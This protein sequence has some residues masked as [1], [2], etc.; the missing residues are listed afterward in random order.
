MMTRLSTRAKNFLM[1]LISQ[2]LRS[3][4]IMAGQPVKPIL[5]ITAGSKHQDNALEFIRLLADWTAPSSQDPE[6]APAKSQ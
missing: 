1:A 6:A 2:T 5:M 4:P 3:T